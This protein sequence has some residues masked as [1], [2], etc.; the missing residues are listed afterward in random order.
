MSVESLQDLYVEELRDL[1]NAENQITKALPKMSKMASKAELRDAFN[2]HLEVTKQ[3]IQRLEDIFETLGKS[4]RGKKCLGMEGLLAEGK[5]Q[6]EEVKKGET[7]DAAMIGAAQKVEHYE[8]AGYGT[9][10]TFAETLG[11][12]NDCQLL[13]DTLDE[14]AETDEK[15]TMIAEQMGVNMEAA[16]QDSEEEGKT[17]SSRSRATNSTKKASSASRS[18]SRG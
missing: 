8:I 10:R 1:Y 11:R 17:M 4:P 2:D 9:A 12:E 13:Q 5:E 15:L 16:E 14:E 7:L 18:R 3:H 6:M